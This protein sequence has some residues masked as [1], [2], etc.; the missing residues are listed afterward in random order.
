M[1]DEKVVDLE[2]PGQRTAR[3]CRRL[4]AGISV[5]FMA[6]G[7]AK[8]PQ[9]NHARQA[10]TSVRYAIAGLY[11]GMTSPEVATAASRAGYRL[12]NESAGNDWS[13]ALK[14]AKEGPY[15]NFNTPLRGISSQEYRRGGEMLSVNFIAMPN[16]PVA[17]L[18][19]YSAPKGVLDFTE[20]QSELV[21]RYGKQTFASRASAPWSMWCPKVAPTA[22]D[23]LKYAHLTI[24]KTNRG[25]DINAEDPTLKEQQARLLR[26]NSGAN[27][28]F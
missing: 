12:V 14:K 21:S 10:Q 20:A 26:K 16:G 13:A 15:V 1:F 3:V 25:I 4:L 9:Q 6:S 7:A 8:A 18:V 17:T 28:S 11:P 24:S 19:S 2:G 27:A 5:L 23:C 22:R